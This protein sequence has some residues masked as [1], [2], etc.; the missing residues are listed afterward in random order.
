MTTAHTG[1][2]AA[3]ERAVDLGGRDGDGV[4]VGP[5]QRGGDAALAQVVG[6]VG[7]GV[8]QEVGAVRLELV[9]GGG[10]GEG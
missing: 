8:A 10:A 9:D 6:G 7:G 5:G 4:G 3:A 2:L 1:G